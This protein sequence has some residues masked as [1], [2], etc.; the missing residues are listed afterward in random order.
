[1]GDGFLRVKFACYRC[2]CL[3]FEADA[4]TV[5]RVCHPP[6]HRTSQNR[7]AQRDKRHQGSRCLPGRSRDRFVLARHCHTSSRRHHQSGGAPFGT[8]L[9]WLA[10][11]GLSYR[12]GVDVRGH[13]VTGIRKEAPITNEI[14]YIMS[15]CVKIHLYVTLSLLNEVRTLAMHIFNQSCQTAETTSLRINVITHA[16]DAVQSDLMDGLLSR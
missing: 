13:L 2:G 1:L 6:H 16:S 8:G 5:E 12:C 9:C 14:S 4:E 10:H 15:A 7:V 11:G 3:D